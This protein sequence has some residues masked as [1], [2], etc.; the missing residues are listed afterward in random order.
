MIKTQLFEMLLR[1]VCRICKVREQDL[2]NYCK[3]QSVVDARVILVYYLRRAGFCN[4]DIATMFLCYGK[5]DNYIPEAKEIV[6]KA[7]GIDKMWYA[8]QDKLSQSYLFGI[9]ATEVKE[10]C[11]ST[12]GG[13]L[14]QIGMKN[15]RSKGN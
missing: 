9:M 12:Y 10:F 2:M 4:E 6:S 3:L 8:F 7:K 11:I 1:E 15:F 14:Y 13:N 5:E